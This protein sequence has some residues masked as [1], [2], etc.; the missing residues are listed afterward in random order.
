MTAPMGA[1]SG[2]NSSVEFFGSKREK[3]GSG[4]LPSGLQG[5]QE[6]SRILPREETRGR[7]RVKEVAASC[8]QMELAEY[9]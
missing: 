5:V 9:S 6:T 4:R 7:M 3:D 2:L 8:G 1:R